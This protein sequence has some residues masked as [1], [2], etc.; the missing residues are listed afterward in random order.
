MWPFPLFFSSRRLEY[1]NRF[2]C[3]R[4]LTF[5][6]S[7]IACRDIRQH[8]L[9]SCISSPSS[10]ASQL[11]AFYGYTRNPRRRL[12]RLLLA[13]P[14][15]GWLASLATTPG[16]HPPPTIK[17]SKIALFRFLASGGLGGAPK[18]RTYMSIWGHGLKRS[19]RSNLRSR[20]QTASE[21]GWGRGIERPQVGVLKYKEVIILQTE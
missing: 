8:S 11:S 14:A 3:L 15:G 9:I 10:V 1:L 4:L 18:S 13:R 20:P 21:V 2:A 12:R 19:R 17:I 16:A 6:W 5:I 7:F